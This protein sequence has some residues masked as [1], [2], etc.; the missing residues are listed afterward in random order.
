MRM[1][2]GHLANAFL[3]AAAKPSDSNILEPYMYAP[4]VV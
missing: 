2:D 3:A 4:A 1:P